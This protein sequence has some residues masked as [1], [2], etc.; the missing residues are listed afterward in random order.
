MATCSPP[1][2]EPRAA[3]AAR[4]TAIEDDCA[5]SLPRCAVCI[6]GLSGVGHVAVDMKAVCVDGDNVP[7]I[8][9]DADRLVLVVSD[10][11]RQRRLASLRGEPGSDTQDR[12]DCG[13]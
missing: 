8:D 12:G 6:N 9:H 7:A 11:L 1:M 13:K 5:F 2:R 10:H 3:Q 4:A